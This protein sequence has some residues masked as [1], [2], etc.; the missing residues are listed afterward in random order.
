MIKTIKNL[1]EMKMPKGL[2]IK[3]ILIGLLENIVNL[4]KNLIV[5]IFRLLH[6]IFE[7][8]KNGCAWIHDIAL[9]IPEFVIK[10]KTREQA[11]EYVKNYSREKEQVKKANASVAFNKG[12]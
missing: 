8:L 12:E 4:P 5:G 9:D 11:L 2:A 6:F 10:G 1:K 7:G 3:V